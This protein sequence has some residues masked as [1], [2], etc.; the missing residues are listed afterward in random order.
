MKFFRISTTLLLVTYGFLGLHAVRAQQ[1][2]GKSDVLLTTMEKEQH[3]GQSELAQRDPQPEAELKK[4]L[5]EMCEQRDLPYGMYAQTMGGKLAP[6]LLYRI[7]VKDGREE[8]VRGAVFGDLDIRSLRS[9]LIAAGNS[10]DVE[11]RFEP[12]AYSVA[13]SALL[14]D[15]LQV[16]RSHTKQHLPE[17]PAPPLGQGRE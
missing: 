11:Q 8:L 10:L 3:R 15:E 6:R 14:F 7:W 2:P 17:Y 4:K 12:V 5:V 13:S 16:K 9:D 1:P